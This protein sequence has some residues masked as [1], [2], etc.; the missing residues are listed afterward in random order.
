MARIQKHLLLVVLGIAVLVPFVVGQA[1]PAGQAPAGGQRGGGAPAAQA[2]RGAPAGPRA[3]TT[4]AGEV[5]NYVRVTDAMLQKP[6][7]SDWL[8]IRRDPYASSYS[9]LT[10]ITAANASQLQLAWAL[11]MTEGGTVQTAPLVHNGVIYTNHANSAGVIQAIDA[12]KGK[13]I[14]EYRTGGVNIA[15][16]GIAIYDD[17]IIFMQSNGRLKAMRHKRQGDLGCRHLGRARKFK[18]AARCERKSD[19]GYVGL[20]GL[21]T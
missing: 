3:G 19:P 2:G 12:V 4:I 5:P 16:R 10:Q 14:W 7:D 6:P 11:A 9:P 18:R 21:H 17:K 8:M 1:P 20:H 13:V 15:Q